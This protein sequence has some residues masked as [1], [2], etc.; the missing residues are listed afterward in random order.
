MP[1]ESKD[2]NKQWGI[3]G[4]AIPGGLLLGMG[5]GFF[6]D[7]VPG[8]LFIGLGGGFLIALLVMVVMQFSKRGE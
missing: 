6:V 2:K 7:N 5:V 3:A 8:G 4:I 1:D